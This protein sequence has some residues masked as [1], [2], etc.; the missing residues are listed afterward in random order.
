MCGA[1]LDAA[2][3]AVAV[4]ARRAAARLGPG[5]HLLGGAVAPL[6]PAI[7]EE[8]IGRRGV[9]VE[10]LALVGRLAVPAEAQPL[11]HLEDVLGELGTVELGVGVLDAQDELATDATGFEPVEQAGAGAADVQ[12]ATRG[13][14]VAVP[15]DGGDRPGLPGGRGARGRRPGRPAR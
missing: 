7:R 3:T 12:V 13:G 8:P 6:G 14:R 1:A 10:P 4:V 15:G 9:A 5:L 2:G 11:E